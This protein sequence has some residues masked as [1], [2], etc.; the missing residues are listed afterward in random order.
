MLNYISFTNTLPSGF[1]EPESWQELEEVLGFNQHRRK[2]L[3]GLKQACYLLAEAG[4]TTV[5]LNGSFITQKELPNDFDACWDTTGIDWNRLDP[6]FLKVTFPRTE[7]KE[8][9][10]GE[11]FPAQ[12]IADF[13]TKE[14]FLD[15]FQTDREGNP[16]G[17]VKL[18]LAKLL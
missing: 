10:G 15:F 17:I 13:K 4:C 8:R 14:T 18:E 5:Y 3:T 12:A 9:F 6:I 16:K 7:Q 1:H 2:L 11:L